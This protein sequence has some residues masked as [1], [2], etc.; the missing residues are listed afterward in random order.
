[1][2]A[3]AASGTAGLWASVDLAFFALTVWREA[4]GEGAA[5]MKG[6]ACS[7]RNRVR[8][9]SWWG[10]SYYEVCT[11]KWQ[12]SAMTASGDPQLGLF[13]ARKD[14]EFDQALWICSEVMAGRLRS[15]VPGADSYHDASIAAPK[16]ATA[17]SFVGQVGR[18]RFH[19]LDR[20]VEKEA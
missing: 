9:P 19:N 20:D 13:P 14:R 10:R 16:W 4:R 17:D 1:V 15:P 2:T 12:Y 18:I 8:R 11:K 3:P 5:G 6:V 7:I